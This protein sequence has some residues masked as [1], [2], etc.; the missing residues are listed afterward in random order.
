MIYRARPCFYYKK[1]IG[2]KGKSERSETEGATPGQESS[3]N[4]A[5]RN[6]MACFADSKKSSL[7]GA[8]I[9]TWKKYEKG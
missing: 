3:M 6:L 1:K 9:C 8:I 4:M 5:D 2:K 7:I